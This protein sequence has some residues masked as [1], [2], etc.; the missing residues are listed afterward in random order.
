MFTYS[1]FSVFPGIWSQ[2]MQLSLEGQWVLVMDYETGVCANDML[3]A[4]DG[5]VPGGTPPG[6]G[7][8][9]LQCGLQLQWFASM[10]AVHYLAEVF[11]E[12]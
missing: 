5:Q 11:S 12:E 1:S 6:R 8:V 9:K 4:C 7:A 2:K 10:G 3:Y